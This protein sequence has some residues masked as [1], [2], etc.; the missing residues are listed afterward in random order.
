MVNVAGG[1]LVSPITAPMKIALKD[2][3][4]EDQDHVRAVLEPYGETP[5][6]MLDT[7]GIAYQLESL[8]HVKSATFEP[9]VFGRATIAF[10]YREPVAKLAVERNAYVDSEGE[11]YI[12]PKGAVVP[13]VRVPR[14]Y[15]DVSG[16][17]I[18]RWPRSGVVTTVGSMQKSLPQ[19][20]YSLELDAQSVL[21]LQVV[22]GPLVVLG[23]ARN[24]E[25]KIQTLAEIYKD[26]ELDLSFGTTVNLMAPER[27]TIK[28]N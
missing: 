16:T 9:N 24:L 20:D 28:T 8:D 2:V 27:P 5:W 1:L 26:P 4:V 7:T 19:L 11:V 6:L 17:A 3:R 21:F 13:I 23:T 25:E 22:E 12:D 14:D 18:G 15:L 10:D